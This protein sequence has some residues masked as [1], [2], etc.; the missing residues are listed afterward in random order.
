MNHKRVLRIYREE[1]LNLRRKRPRRRVAAAHRMDR[2]ELSHIDQCWSMFC[3]RSTIQWA[4]NQSVN[5][6]R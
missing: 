3:R 6:S 4:T 5:C 2:P 1:D